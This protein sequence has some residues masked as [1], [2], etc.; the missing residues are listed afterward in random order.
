MPVYQYEGVHYDLP[1]GL[2]NEQAIAKIQS[3][4]GVSAQPARP[5]QTEYTAEQ[6]APSSPEDVGFSGEAPIRAR[7]KAAN[8]PPSILQ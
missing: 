5:R 4:L 1:D 3:Y 2:S 7:S 6:M 8:R